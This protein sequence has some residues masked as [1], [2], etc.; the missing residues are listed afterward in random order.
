MTLT[1]NP[2][3]ANR[4]GAREAELLSLGIDTPVIHDGQGNVTVTLSVR[5]LEEIIEALDGPGVRHYVDED[6]LAV[7]YEEGVKEGRARVMAELEEF[8]AA[9]KASAS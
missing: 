9:K 1:E 3:A 5:K 2:N 4:D 6:D 8:A 7:A